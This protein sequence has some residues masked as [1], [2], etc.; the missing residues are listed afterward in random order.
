MRDEDVTAANLANVL[1]TIDAFLSKID[2][3]YLTLDLDVLPHWQMEAVSAPA[4]RGVDI[5]VIEAILT[6]IS[7]APVEWPL[8]DVVE[9]NPSLDPAG[10]AARTA[11]RLIDILA[12]E[13]LL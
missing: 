11:A 9:F 1:K 12:R 8:S 3:L 10:N 4:A 7:K 6:H 2:V 13:M 5:A